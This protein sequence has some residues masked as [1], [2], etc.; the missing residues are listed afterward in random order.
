AHPGPTE[1]L[2]A[3]QTKLLKS[4]KGTTL[5]LKTFLPLVVKYDL[6]GEFPS[7]S[8]HRYLHEKKLGRADLSKLDADNRRHIKEYIENIYTMEQLTRV[9]TNLALL[10][11]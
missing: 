6:A 5:N 10:K 2:Q 1:S 11:K 9:Q 8:S 7:Y 4:L 3:E